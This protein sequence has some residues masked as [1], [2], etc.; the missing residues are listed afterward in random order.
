MATFR[1]A[2]KDA[3]GKTIEGTI[4]AAGKGEVVSELRKQDLVVIRVEEGKKGK[5]AKGDK[6]ASGGNG[7]E[8]ASGGFNFNITLFKPKPA[9]TRTELVLFTRQLATMIA[10]GISL[11]EAL[12]V[13]GDQADTPAFGMVCNNLA[14]SLRGGSDLSAAMGQMPKVFTELYVSMVAAGE[15]SGQMDVIL[16]RLADYQESAESLQREIK[17][18]MTYPVVSLVLVLGITTFLLLGVVPTFRQVFES[19]DAELP[20]LTEFV[21]GASDWLKGNWMIAFGAMFG[22][23]FGLSLYKKTSHGELVFDHLKLKLPIFGPLLRKVALARFSRTFATLVRSGVPILGTL[24]IVSATAGNKVISNVVDKAQISVRNGDMLSEPLSESTVFPT[25]VTRM[26]GIGERSGALEALLEKI[27]EFYD[28]Q[29]K[30]QIKSLTSLI[31]P[32]LISFMGIM[33]GVVVLA[34][35]LPI[36]D[37]V[38]K[39][40]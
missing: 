19:L 30:A 16:E 12:E 32:L 26:I 6:K 36:L 34:V 13:L 15:V 35:F 14:N 25:M 1:Y 29:V 39:L 22:T 24:E 7:K 10:A 3:S 9:A 40:A 38:G 20:A 37:I 31:E 33:V 2:A 27:A 21:L 28:A 5:K 17:S 23:V 18:A 8:K 4:Q 11:L